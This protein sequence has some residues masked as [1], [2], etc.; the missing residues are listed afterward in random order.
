ME[1]N[2]TKTKP[3]AACRIW[4]NDCPAANF[5]RSDAILDNLAREV[6]EPERNALFN[7]CGGNG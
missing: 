6:P 2:Q 1:R 5:A 3:F 7:F 4:S